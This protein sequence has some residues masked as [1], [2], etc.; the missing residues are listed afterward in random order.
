VGGIYV[1]VGGCCGGGASS[2]PDTATTIIIIMITITATAMPAYNNSLLFL[3]FSGTF[4]W[5]LGGG[6]PNPVSILY[7]YSAMQKISLGKIIA[8]KYQHQMLY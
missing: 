2:P 7:L 3:G 1:D 6:G 5:N 4:P 8:C